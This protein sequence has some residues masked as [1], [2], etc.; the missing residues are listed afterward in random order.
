MQPSDP[1]ANSRV[2]TPAPM[3]TSKHRL[4]VRGGGFGLNGLVEDAIETLDEG[5]WVWLTLEKIEH[6]LCPPWFEL[7]HERMTGWTEF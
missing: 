5:G 3:P 6:A 4:P 7:S 1:P 2:R